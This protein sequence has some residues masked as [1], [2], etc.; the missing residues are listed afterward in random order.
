[1]TRTN[2]LCGAVL[3]ALA[4][5]LVLTGC[6]GGSGGEA[7]R[8]QTQ[9]TNPYAGRY[10]GIATQ[11]GQM[12]M[13]VIVRVL[14]TGVAQA[15]VFGP[16]LDCLYRTTGTVSDAGAASWTVTAKDYSSAPLTIN[17]AGSFTGVG[18]ALAG[19]GTWT[20]Y[21]A[22]TREWKASLI[23]PPSRITNA[24]SWDFI[25]P[26]RG[27]GGTYKYTQAFG[28]LARS[29]GTPILAL[30]FNGPSTFAGTLAL[31]PADGVIVI[32]NPGLAPIGEPYG[33]GPVNVLLS[34]WKL[35]WY[36]SYLKSE[37]GAASTVTLSAK[38]VRLGGMVSG[39]LHSDLK[40]VGSAPPIRYSDVPFQNIR[41]IR[42]YR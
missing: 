19:A 24:G 6:G 42:D 29:Q 36:R 4:V 1:M 34:K 35:D 31:A 25:F 7:G 39:T 20:G 17:F 10:C 5:V 12:A 32:P 23:E 26:T 14:T 15:A 11:N 37:V 16:K 18:T 27:G 22:G 38:A 21:G 28:V 30:V 13:I 3:V 8:L 40:S 41:I 2:L 9:S 33:V